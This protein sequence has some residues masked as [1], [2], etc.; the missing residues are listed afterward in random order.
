MVEVRILDAGELV[1]EI[2]ECI[3]ESEIIRIAV[4]FCK[5]KGFE[6]INESLKKALEDRKIIKFIVGMSS[7]YGI[8]DPYVLDQL[9]KIKKVFR[10]NFSVRYYDNPGFHPKLFIFDSVKRVR[11][12]VGSS[13]LTGGGLHNNIEA[14]IML[15][16]TKKQKI[17]KSITKKFD[18]WFEN[19]YRLKCDKVSKYKK[20]FRRFKLPQKL[21]KRIRQE[22]T[23]LPKPEGKTGEIHISERSSFWKVAPGERGTQW[24]LWED[25]IEN[26]VG[27]IAIGW[28]GL[29]CFVA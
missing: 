6:E 1:H 5:R 7:D 23:P 28:E 11:I 8:T 21:Q 19:A 22:R 18:Y 29:N 24:D 26:E 9:L 25:E 14:N 12:I 20:L 13:N 17:V 10:N 3:A 16:T 15:D 2:K 4:A 27:I